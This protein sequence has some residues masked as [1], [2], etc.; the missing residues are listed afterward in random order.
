MPSVLLEG[1]DD[2]GLVVISVLLPTDGHLLSRPRDV[3]HSNS[4]SL[5]VRVYSINT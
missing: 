5:W 1:T 2:P 4:T 3:L